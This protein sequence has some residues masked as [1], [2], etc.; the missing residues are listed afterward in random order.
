ML[1]FYGK[2]YPSGSSKAI[3]VPSRILEIGGFKEGD[4]IEVR[5]KAV[6]NKTK[7]DNATE[8]KFEP[9]NERED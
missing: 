5:V 8:G 7:Q 9:L 4:I 1:L 2:I 6:D 3:I